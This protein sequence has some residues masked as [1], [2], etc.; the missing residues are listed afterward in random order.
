MSHIASQERRFCTEL[1]MRF[2]SCWSFSFCSTF[3]HFFSCFWTIWRREQKAAWLPATSTVNGLC[4]NCPCRA[5]L[6]W[7]RIGTQHYLLLL[8]LDAVQEAVGL[9]KYFRLILSR[10]VIKSRVSVDL[11]AGKAGKSCSPHYPLNSL[12]SLFPWVRPCLLF[13]FPS[14]TM[15]PP[16]ENICSWQRLSP[17]TKLAVPHKVI[18]TTRQQTFPFASPPPRSSQLKEQQQKYCLQIAA[19]PRPKAGWTCVVKVAD[20][21]IQT[22]V[23]FCRLPGSGHTKRERQKEISNCGN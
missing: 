19:T 23:D 10:Q 5:R 4:G 8:L 21:G 15:H 12:L 2:R 3:R 13:F 22:Y 1:T 16:I 17:I 6:F 7:P 20:L 9:H 14:N 11:K 18:R